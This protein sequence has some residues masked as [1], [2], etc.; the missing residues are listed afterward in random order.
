MKRESIISVQNVTKRY[1]LFD[2][3]QDRLKRML[4]GR[5]G[6]GYGREFV[7]LDDIS[8]EIE[9]GESVGIIGKNGAG[10]STLLQ[11]IVGTLPA[12]SGIVGVRG[13]IAALLEL[14]AGF[15]MDFTG[16]E[17]VYMTSRFLGMNRR[18]TDLQ[19]E[20]IERFADIGEFMDQPV[21]TYSSG[22]LVRLGFAVQTAVEPD[23]LVVDEALSV[24]DFFFQ[25]KC[26]RRMQELREKGVTL[27]L[28]SH[29][30]ASVRDLCR[31]AV[32][33][34][35]GGLAYD[36]SCHEAISRYFRD[37]AGKLENEVVK[38]RQCPNSQGKALL[39]K[40]GKIACWMNDVPETTTGKKAVFVGLAMVNSDGNPVLKTMI[41]ET[42]TLKALYRVNTDDPVHVSLIIKNKFDQVVTSTGSYL[43]SV[44]PVRLSLGD[45]SLFEMELACQLE[46]G[47]YTF[48]LV[49]GSPTGMNKGVSFDRTP[50]LGPLKVE[51]DYENRKAP[52]LGMFGLPV[53]CRFIYYGSEGCN[54]EIPDPVSPAASSN[55]V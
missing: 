42:V 2:R 52:F 47:L 13:R 51:W 23:V 37:R 32:L 11:I 10:K 17:N 45:Y 31:R 40:F 41:G 30:M 19:F 18:E 44:E 55:E 35:K 38:E 7:A 20:E 4:L 27:L 36:G 24:G 25:Q 54:T 3:P 6:K 49:L 22:M 12:S 14:G 46:A 9:K 33:L 5:F 48:S 16:R 26:M 34:K 1:F 39:E 21:R 43:H 53:K 8:F 15:N 29:D 50:W 28:V